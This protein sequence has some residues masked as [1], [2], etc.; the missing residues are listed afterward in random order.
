MAVW[1][2]FIFY[3][4]SFVRFYWKSQLALKEQPWHG[5]LHHFNY[6]LFYSGKWK[7]PRAKHII[8]RPKR[9]HDLNITSLKKKAVGW[10]F[11]EIF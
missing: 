5:F 8:L 1:C 3:E 7:Y 10:D 2:V 9:L 11:L 6:Q 4:S